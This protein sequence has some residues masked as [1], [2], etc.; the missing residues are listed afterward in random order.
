MPSRE[1]ATELSIIGNEAQGNWQRNS[2]EP[3]T[4]I[5]EASQETGC[6]RWNQESSY[7]VPSG[8]SLLCLQMEVRLTAEAARSPMEPSTFTVRLLRKTWCQ[9]SDRQISE[10]S[11]LTQP[12]L[13]FTGLSSVNECT[14]GVIF[15]FCLPMAVGL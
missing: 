12:E 9:S 6:D 15:H 14:E 13:A 5:R 2:G 8:P 1:P 7:G 3:G 4:K 10:Q 11:V